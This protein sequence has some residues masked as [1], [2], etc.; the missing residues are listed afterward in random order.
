LASKAGMSWGTGRMVG[1]LIGARSMVARHVW[2]SRLP[3]RTACDLASL[4]NR[5]TR[6]AG[7]LVRPLQAG[8]QAIGIVWNNRH[9]R[10]C[11]SLRITA[12]LVFLAQLLAQASLKN[13]SRGRHDHLTLSIYQ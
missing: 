8:A 3:G 10:L 13:I 7:K 12:G 1:S 4:G 2:G 9:G 5:L 6:Q 11:P